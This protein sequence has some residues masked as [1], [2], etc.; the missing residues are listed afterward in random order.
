[1][2]QESA[3]CAE[4]AITVLA[5]REPNRQLGESVIQSLEG[6][7]VAELPIVAK[8]DGEQPFA[9]GTAMATSEGRSAASA[10]TRTLSANQS[11]SSSALGPDRR[12]AGVLAFRQS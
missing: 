1:M 8:Q 4:E 3:E 12:I 7:R 11:W 5:E 6:L 9:D 10:D 2:T